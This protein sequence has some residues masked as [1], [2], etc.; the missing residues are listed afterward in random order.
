MFN[1]N[2]TAEN[3]RKAGNYIPEYV[4]EIMQDLKCK[5]EDVEIIETD[6]LF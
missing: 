3:L 5:F 1:P 4:N 2:E 6:G